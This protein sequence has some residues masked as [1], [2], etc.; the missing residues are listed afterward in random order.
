MSCQLPSG[1]GRLLLLSL[2]LMALPLAC[3]DDEPCDSDEESIGPGC[4]PR[5][6]GGSSGSSS[7]EPTSGAGADAGGAGPGGGNPD[8]TFG[9]PCESDADCGGDAPLC[10]N[11]QF[12]Y[13]LQTECQEGEQNEGACPADWTCFKYEDNP[14]ACIKL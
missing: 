4:F 14:S 12:H 11:Q 5:A 3:K 10:D 6:A 2:A 9:T 8:A 7:G 13:C 1:A